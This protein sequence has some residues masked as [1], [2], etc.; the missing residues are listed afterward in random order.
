M[1]FLANIHR[2]DNCSVD[3]ADMASAME[4]AG[5]IRC[6]A[7]HHW[8]QASSQLTIVQKIAYVSCGIIKFQALHFSPALYDYVVKDLR[9]AI[10]LVLNKVTHHSPPP[11]LLSSNHSVG[12]P[13]AASSSHCLASL[14]SLQVSSAQ[15]RL[16]HLPS[17][18]VCLHWHQQERYECEWVCV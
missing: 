7:A 13:G 12:W 6:G 16:L 17:R 8:H 14:L 4:G 3:R 18:P 5:D 1:K 2:F 11:S 9:K 15:C 10:V